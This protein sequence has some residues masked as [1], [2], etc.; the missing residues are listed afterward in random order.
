MDRFNKA[1]LEI[2]DL[3]PAVALHHLTTA[4]KPGSFIN[5]ICKKPPSDSGCTL[6]LDQSFLPL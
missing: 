2:R 5:S 6:F 3:N 4:L 1:T